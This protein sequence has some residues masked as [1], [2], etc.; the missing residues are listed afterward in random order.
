MEESTTDECDKSSLSREEKEFQQVTSMAV[1][2]AIG[3][4]VLLVAMA[5]AIAHR[6]KVLAEKRKSINRTSLPFSSN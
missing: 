4:A 6:R 3:L 2:I 1:G 5:I